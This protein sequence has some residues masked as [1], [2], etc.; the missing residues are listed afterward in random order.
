MPYIRYALSVIDSAGPIIISTQ[1]IFRI[2]VVNPHTIC[3][4]LLTRTMHVSIDPAGLSV[5]LPILSI[6][7]SPVA[8]V[9]GGWGVIEQRVVDCKES[10]GLSLVAHPILSTV[11]YTT[12][13][14]SNIHTNNDLYI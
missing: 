11:P 4:Q 9:L 5:Y 2:S 14:H 12:H 3:E 7:P 6:Y 10:P 8:I 1:S 13:V